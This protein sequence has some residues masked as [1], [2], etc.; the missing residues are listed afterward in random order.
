MSGEAKVV[1]VEVVAV[2]VVW[3]QEA[4]AEEEELQKDFVAGGPG[5]LAAEFD[6]MD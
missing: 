6:V 5:L 3:V 2:E 1:L 4:E